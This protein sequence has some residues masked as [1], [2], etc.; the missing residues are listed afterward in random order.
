MNKVRRFLKTLITFVAEKDGNT[1]TSSFEY[2]MEA[3]AKCPTNEGKL[4]VS[5]EPR[6]KAD[7]VS[8]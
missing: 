4:S 7:I 8:N 3:L 2:V 5:V 1:I 6:E